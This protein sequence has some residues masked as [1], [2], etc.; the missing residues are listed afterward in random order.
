MRSSTIAA[1]LRTPPHLAVG[2]GHRRLL[3]AGLVVAGFFAAKFVDE[4]LDVRA[5]LEAA[6]SR[7]GNVTEL[8][9]SGDQAQFDAVAAEVL[10]LHLQRR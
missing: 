7:L 2:T 9:R 8:V 5:D 3:I 4:A 10:A 1:P 6:Q